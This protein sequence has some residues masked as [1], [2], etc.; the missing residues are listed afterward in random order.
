LSVLVYI[1]LLTLAIHPLFLYL[2]SCRIGYKMVDPPPSNV[3]FFVFSFLRSSHYIVVFSLPPSHIVYSCSILK[4]LY[5]FT[6]ANLFVS[7][8]PT[9]RSASR[10]TPNLQPY[11]SNS[12][13]IALSFRTLANLH[14]IYTPSL[15][16]IPHPSPFL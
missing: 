12:S 9:A 3:L 14:C 10:L 4:S 6:S 8:V 11:D 13:L 15:H 1:L 7:S 2:R 5:H 16:Q